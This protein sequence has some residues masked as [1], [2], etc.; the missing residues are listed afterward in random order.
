M[1]YHTWNFSHQTQEEEENKYPRGH[2]HNQHNQ[3]QVD[4]MYVLI[5]LAA[6]NIFLQLLLRVLLI[7][8]LCSNN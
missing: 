3:N 2:V 6:S 7:C 4:P 1:S 8:Y 5:V